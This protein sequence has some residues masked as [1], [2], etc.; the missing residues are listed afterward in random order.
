M[1]E[2]R[3]ILSIYGSPVDQKY[4]HVCTIGLYAITKK[5]NVLYR[6]IIKGGKSAQ[7]CSHKFFFYF[8][9]LV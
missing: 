1:Q 9:E 6:M 3:K 8:F 4:K 2:L 7:K 5:I